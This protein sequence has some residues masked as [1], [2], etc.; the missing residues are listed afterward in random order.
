M[1][2]NKEGGREDVPGS[3][4]KEMCENWGELQ[5]FVEKIHRDIAVANRSIKLEVQKIFSGIAKIV[6]GWSTPKSLILPQDQAV[7]LQFQKSRLLTVSVSVSVWTLV[8]ISLERYFAICR[9]FTS[10]QWQTISHSYKVVVWVWVGSF[11]TMLPIAG[12][13]RLLP[14]KLPNRYKCRDVWPNVTL[15]RVFNLYLD[16]V[17]LVVPLLIMIV[18]YSLIIHTLYTGLHRETEA[19]PLRFLA[20][21]SQDLPTNRNTRRKSVVLQ[22]TED[23][24]YSTF[25]LT[26]RSRMMVQRHLVIKGNYNKGRV[27]KKRIIRML[28]VIVMNF[29]ICWA[30]LFVI[31]TWALYDPKAI[32]RKLPPTAISVIHLMAYFS[33]SCNP[34]IYFFMHSK[35]RQAFMSI[36]SCRRRRRWRSSRLSKKS[37][38]LNSMCSVRAVS[39][40]NNPATGLE[41]HSLREVETPNLL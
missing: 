34:V 14:T 29:F 2:S 1:S 35:Y 21:R 27:A 13:S 26:S 8:S 25:S 30:P 4:I 11:L 33:S 5:S 40:H 12:L 22:T 28:F 17:L 24:S 31:N 38:T 9:P 20:N 32:Y 19:F 6:T 16:G 15:E 39:A 41:S 23:K 36:F 3:L 18:M 10:R 7:F 37:V